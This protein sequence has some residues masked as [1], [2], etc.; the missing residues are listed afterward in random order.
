MARF[1]WQPNRLYPPLVQN[2]NIT[3]GNR[4]DPSHWETRKTHK[5][6]GLRITH[7]GPSSEIQSEISYGSRT[8]IGPETSTET[9]VKHVLKPVVNLYRELSQGPRGLLKPRA[10]P[11]TKSA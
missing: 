6:I 11:S 2:P 7:P 10:A 5:E 4:G 8:G 1:A 3:F 9:I